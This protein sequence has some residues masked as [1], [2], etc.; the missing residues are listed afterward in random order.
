MQVVL[1]PQAEADLAAA[2]DWYDNEAPG[3]GRRFMDEFLTIARQ[4][5]D[6]P[7]L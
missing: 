6:N 1:T 4:L 3:L 2:R 5:A 7:G